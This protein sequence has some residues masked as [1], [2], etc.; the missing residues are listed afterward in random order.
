ME[1]SLKAVIL[2]WY[3]YHPTLSI[4]ES[5]AVFDLYAQFFANSLK[6]AVLPNTTQREYS[7]FS[8]FIP[9]WCPHGIAKMFNG[10]GDAITTECIEQ[11]FPQVEEIFHLSDYKADKISY[12]NT[13]H[14]IIH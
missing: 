13:I 1:N 5:N 14:K 6:S 12:S 7:F 2:L 8:L 10:K 11:I 4:T 9:F 3:V